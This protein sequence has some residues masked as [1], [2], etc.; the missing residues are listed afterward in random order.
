MSCLK[1]FYE[2]VDKTN[3]ETLMLILQETTSILSNLTVS[4][5]KHAFIASKEIWKSDVFAMGTK[6]IDIVSILLSH[7]PG[8]LNYSFIEGISWFF[9]CVTYKVLDTYID[10]MVNG[11]GQDFI[12][13]VVNKFLAF[14]MRRTSSGRIQDSADSES[15]VQI[16]LNAV[17]ILANIC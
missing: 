4:R 13:K 9:S 17:N 10:S 5:G 1:S 11:L 2:I 16:Q 12:S 8:D 7:E 3:F 15:I 14:A 6:M